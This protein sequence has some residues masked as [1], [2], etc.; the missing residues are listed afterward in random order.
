MEEVIFIRAQSKSGGLTSLTI[1]GVALVLGS[2]VMLWLPVELRLAGIFIISG[3][4]VAMLIGW[5]KLR[6]PE[7]SLQL[8][9]SAIKYHHRSGQWQIKWENIARIDVPRVQRELQHQSLTMVG[10][11]IHDYDDF[12]QQI[13]PRLMSNILM[14]QRAL[15]I[16][17]FKDQYKEGTKSINDYGDYLV[18]DT[19]YTSENGQKYTGLQAMFAHRMNRLREGLGYDL[20]INAAELDRSAEEFVSLLKE[21]KSAT[22]E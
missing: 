3:S 11:R 13:S 10:I 5:F 2:M 9:K 4:L 21:C 19:E 16:Q 18:E 7:H 17:T 22:Q 1:G 8:T 14:E 20:Y 12:L 15:L 6:E